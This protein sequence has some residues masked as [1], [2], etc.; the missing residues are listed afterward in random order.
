MNNIVTETTDNTEAVIIEWREQLMND[1]TA[2]W[3]IM[4]T[5]VES[6]DIDTSDDEHIRVTL[7]GHTW[8]AGTFESRI[9]QTFLVYTKPDKDGDNYY[10]PDGPLVVMPCTIQFDHRAEQALRIAAVITSAA[11]ELRMFEQESND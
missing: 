1:P 9:E 5:W 11:T 2:T 8:T 6:L 7:K 4:P 10:T 3:P